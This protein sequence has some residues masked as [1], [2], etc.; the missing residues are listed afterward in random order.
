MITVLTNS[1]DTARLLIVSA[2]DC[3]VVHVDN[4]SCSQ[5]NKRWS[6]V[7]IVLF[8]QFLR[9]TQQQF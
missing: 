1:E 6:K 2:D 4:S 9:R 5:S 3:E 8:I 7:I